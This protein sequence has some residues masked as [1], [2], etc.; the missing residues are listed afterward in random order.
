[1]DIIN[2]E[3]NLLN[4]FTI[5]LLRI[6][7]TLI[8]NYLYNFFVIIGLLLGYKLSPLEANTI[9]QEQKTQ[10]QQAAVPQTP[11]SA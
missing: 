1:M 7:D 6:I 8:V 5:Y 10:N 2:V 4:K 11:N 9:V 3:N